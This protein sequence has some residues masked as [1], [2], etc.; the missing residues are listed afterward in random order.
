M[1]G[2]L[3]GNPLADLANVRKITLRVKQGVTPRS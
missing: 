2:P 3:E 1:T